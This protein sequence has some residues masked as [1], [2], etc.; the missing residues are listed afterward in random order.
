MKDFSSKN[1]NS[2]LNRSLAVRSNIAVIGNKDTVLLFKALG[3][4]VFFTDNYDAKELLNQLA[5]REYRIILITEREAIIAGDV[6]DSLA[7]QPYPVILPI[8]DGVQSYG[9]AFDRI[10]LNMEKVIGSS[11]GAG[12]LQ[13]GQGE[14]YQR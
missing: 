9:L 5:Q 12:G 6:I 3:M 11:G 8:P 10:K 4:D 13:E 7:H 14:N 1:K 2:N